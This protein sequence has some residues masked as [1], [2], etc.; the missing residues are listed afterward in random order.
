MPAVAPLL[1][2]LFVPRCAA[3]DRRVRA[4]QVF[5]EACEGSLYELGPA[6]PRCAQPAA[7]ATA[8][9]CR[10]CRA[11]PPP[12][13]AATAAYRYG[14]ELAVALCRLKFG[15]RPDLARALAPLVAAPLARFAAG[16]DLAVP[17]PLARRRRLRRGYNQSALLLAHAAAGVIEVDAASLRKIRATCA[18]AG[19]G[20]RRRRDNIAGAFQVARRR[21]HRVCGRRILLFDDVMTTG[22]T[23]SA[24]ARALLAAG[25]AEVRCVC[26]ARAE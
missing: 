25:A 3:C 21:A 15:C 19:L 11:E 13:S 17:V 18:Q 7:G 9:L 12:F 14:G 24:C 6:C 20:A 26:L 5:C 4:G 8:V 2:L 10:R 22:A 16:A 1:D 23:L